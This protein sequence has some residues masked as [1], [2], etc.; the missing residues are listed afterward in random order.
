MSS[1]L[2]C[3]THQQNDTVCHSTVYSLLVCHSTV[4]S[5][6]VCHSTVYSLLVCHTYSVLTVDVPQYSVAYSLGIVG[7]KDARDPQYPDRVYTM[8]YRVS[9]HHDTETGCTP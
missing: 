4:Y 7:G 3:N 8:M 2:A 1:S 9:V 6:L 5:L